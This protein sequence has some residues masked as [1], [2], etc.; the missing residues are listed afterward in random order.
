[1]TLNNISSHPISKPDLMRGAINYPSS[2]ST[3]EELIDHQPQPSKAEA[4]TA[5]IKGSPVG[6]TAILPALIALNDLELANL[7]F[8]SVADFFALLSNLPSTLKHLK[9]RTITFG[10]GVRTGFG[11]IL[12]A[13]CPVSLPSLRAASLRRPKNHDL[14]EFIQKT[15]LLLDLSIETEHRDIQTFRRGFDPAASI[16]PSEDIALEDAELED[17]NLISK[18]RD[19]VRG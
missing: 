13:D 2:S 14:G 16:L 5:K 19:E 11:T 15:S 7:S 17:S 6:N 8:S 18:R 3:F 9:N 1:M 4:L 12:I 10:D